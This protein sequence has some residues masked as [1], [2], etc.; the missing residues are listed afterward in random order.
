MGSYPAGGDQPPRVGLSTYREPAAWGVWNAAADLLPAR[1]AQ[2]V[3]QAGGAALL[4]P[5][6]PAPTVPAVLGGL[7]GLLL[8][9]GADVDPDRYGA[10]RDPATQQARQDRDEWE[11]ALT[12]EAIGAD[13]PILAV[14]RGMQILNVTLGGNLI[15]DLPAVLGT[16]VHCPTVGVHERHSVAVQPGSRLAGVLGERADVATYHHQ[17]VDRLGAGLTAT[18]WAADGTIEAVELTGRSWVFGVQWHPEA[19]KGAALFSA[20][21]QA[22]RERQRTPVLAG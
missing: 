3:Q 6:G 12:H 19:Y 17:A 20:F 13:L 15:Q 1:Y 21:V 7:H 18:G 4:L 10:G 11:L 9:G 8:A 2:S 14:C 22:C 5:P 16:D